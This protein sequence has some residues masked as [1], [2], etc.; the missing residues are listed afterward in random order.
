MA[1][2]VSHL[3]NPNFKE[4]RRLN[5]DIKLAYTVGLLPNTRFK[6]FFIAFL[7]IGTNISLPP[8]VIAKSSLP[9]TP[10]YLKM[11]HSGGTIFS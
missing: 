6:F 4:A 11:V 1:T 9:I 8:V 3:P 10:L 7:R 2:F 5:F